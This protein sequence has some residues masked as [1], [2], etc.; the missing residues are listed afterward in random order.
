MT[1]SA[2]L[3]L[4]LGQHTF[5]YYTL[6]TLI[7]WRLLIRIIR[8]SLHSL[9]TWHDFLL[10]HVVAKKNKLIKLEGVRTTL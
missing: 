3:M 7:Y 10:D 4:K 8:Y 2:V 1:P 6:L 9:F 5:K